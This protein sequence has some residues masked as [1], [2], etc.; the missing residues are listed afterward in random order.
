MNHRHMRDMLRPLN[1]APRAILLSAATLMQQCWQ[2]RL[3][4]LCPDEPTVVEL[5]Q[6]EYDVEITFYTIR[7]DEPPGKPVRNS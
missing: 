1:E 2:G 6:T 4:Q 7:L 3:N 5:Y